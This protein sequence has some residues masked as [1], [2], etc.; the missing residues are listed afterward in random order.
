M[1]RLL[2]IT[3]NF[4]PSVSIGTQRILRICKYLDP[5]Q[6]S[7]SVLTLKEAYYPDAKHGIAAGFLETLKRLQVYRTHKCDVMFYLVSIRERMRTRFFPAA[8]QRPGTVRSE[9]KERETEGGAPLTGIV[10]QRGFWQK[11][12]DFCTDILQFPDRHITWLPFAM[13]KGYRTIKRESIEVI[14]SSSPPHSLHIIA[15]LLKILTGTKLVVD[16]RDPWARSPWHDEV[17]ILNGFERWKHRRIQKFER[18]VVQQA[19]TVVLIT[20]EMRDDFVN[21]YNDLSTQKFQFFPN[22][23]DPEN[24]QYAVAHASHNGHKPS[25]VTFIHA[26][27]LY[28]YRDPSP[29]LHALENLFVRGEIDE[30]RLACLFIGTITG[31]LSAIPDM[32]QKKSIRNMVTFLPPVS[33]QQV[34]EYMAQSHVLILLQPVT[35]LQL[36]GKFFDYLCLGKPIFAVGEKDSAVEHT[37]E[38]GYGIFA[39]YNN[40]ADVEKALLF[41]YHNPT[42]NIEFIQKNRRVFDMSYSIQTLSNILHA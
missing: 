39:N 2:I 19:D 26:G 11:V 30:K 25:K 36:P 42:Y 10:L 21:Y 29:I 40:V 41:L 6:W 20:R 31:E 12:K 17:R 35:K 8:P 24:L 13:W 27:T 37:I 34:M 9:S 3:T 15:A 16:F 22:G 4:P 38:E 14:F 23:Y 33:Y 7:I 28:K 18:W 5:S 1:K 32:A